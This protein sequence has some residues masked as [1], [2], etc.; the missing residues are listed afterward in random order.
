MECQMIADDRADDPMGP[1]MMPEWEVH[2]FIWSSQWFKNVRIPE[3]EEIREPLN[4]GN[5]W[6]LYC[7]ALEP[8]CFGIYL[9]S[10]SNCSAVYGDDNV[11]HWWAYRIFSDEA[12]D[13]LVK[14]YD[15]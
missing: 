4:D 15:S 9:G 14:L 6:M 2:A 10:T 5:H 1:Y 7:G 12:I 8:E 3:W 11:R 13:S